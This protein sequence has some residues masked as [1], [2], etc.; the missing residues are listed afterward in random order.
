[1]TQFVLS[2]QEMQMRADGDGVFVQSTTTSTCN[3]CSCM[4]VALCAHEGDDA[5]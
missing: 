5:R 3:P 2:L 1:M 4:S